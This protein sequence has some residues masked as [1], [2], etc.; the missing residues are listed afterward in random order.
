MKK[1]KN[2]ILPAGDAIPAK[3][4]PLAP[5]GSLT[6]TIDMS[7]LR[8]MT[9]AELRALRDALHHAQGLLTAF[10]CQPRFA[11]EAKHT[12]NTA[13]D[14]I[15]TICEF[16]AGYETGVI[17]VAKAAK[18]ASE[19]EAEWQNWTL[20]SFYADMTDDLADF[21][22]MASEAVRN[23]ATVKFHEDHNLRCRGAA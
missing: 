10:G 7:A 17:N 6:C 23:V 8:R 11:G 16:L 22:V 2:S 18:P 20:L 5:R 13:G 1:P 19:R 14:I 3:P 9:M 15:E 4:D 12:Q 21:A